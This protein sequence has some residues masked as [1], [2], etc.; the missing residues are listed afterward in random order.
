MRLDD[1]QASENVEDR[2]GR[3]GGFRFPGGGRR[4]R[5]P[6]GRRG[7]GLGIG[8]I[9]I[10]VI[11][12]FL[13]GINPL[14]MLLG[15]GGGVPSQVEYQQPKT[16]QPTTAQQDEMKT[17]VSKVLATT[18]ETWTKQFAGQSKRY[19]A[20]KMVLFSGFVNSACGA[21]QAAM[22]P[23]Y[24]PADSKV[25]IDLSFY[26]DMQT[27]LGA[28]GDFAQAY[29]IAHEVGHHIQNLLGIAAK[30]TQTRMRVSKAEGNELS[31]RMEL[32]ADCLAGIWARDNQDI[33]ERGDIEEG[34][35]AASAIGDDRLQRR[36][37]GQVVPESFTHGSSAQRVRWFKQGLQTGDMRQCDTFS[38]R[39]L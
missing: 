20:P 24:C 7:G 32:Q 10:I 14:E 19:Q 34:L 30:V 4:M 3:G 36:Q 22:G 35:N 8:G 13:F 29:V 37:T 17:F 6:M 5:I 23:F 38:A 16:Q 9:I 39:Q 18:E 26:R 15:G 31:V 2:R 21:A 25:Y 12:S 1:K 28:P 33:L 11:I 27:K